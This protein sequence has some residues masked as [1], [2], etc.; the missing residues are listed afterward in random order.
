MITMET[1]ELQYQAIELKPETLQEKLESIQLEYDPG[2]Y[3][4]EAQRIIQNY[5]E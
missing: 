4:T 1:T 2:G 5:Y 3:E